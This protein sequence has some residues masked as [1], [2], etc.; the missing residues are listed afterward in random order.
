MVTVELALGMPALVLMGLVL[1]WLVGLGAAQGGLVQAARE[2][3]RAAGRGDS[4]TQVLAAVHQV[5]PDAGVAVRRTRDRV[6]VIVH[7]RREPPLRLLRPLARELRASATG[8][9]EQP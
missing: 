4:P 6:E 5:A 3:A 8:W 9:R 2:G 7:L 1:A